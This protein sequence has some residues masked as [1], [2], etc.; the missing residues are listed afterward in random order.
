MP[1]G[2]RLLQSLGWDWEQFRQLLDSAPV[3]VSL[4]DHSHRFLYVNTEWCTSHGWTEDTV[5]GR[6]VAE[7]FNETS[8]AQ[9]VEL[10]VRALAGEA[11]EWYGWTESYRFGRRYVRRICVPLRY[12]SGGRGILHYQS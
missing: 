6:T 5:R 12:S 2:D 11:V 10:G 4:Y 1:G 3:R 8:H 7:L 9:V